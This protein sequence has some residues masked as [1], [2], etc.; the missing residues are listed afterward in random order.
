MA[1]IGETMSSDDGKVE[2]A[3]GIK[4]WKPFIFRRRFLIDMLPV[5]SRNWAKPL[6]ESSGLPRSLLVSRP[7]R[8]RDPCMEWHVSGQARAW[9]AW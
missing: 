2:K 7:T 5:S 8:V 6:S 9:H 1:A 3:M 4:S